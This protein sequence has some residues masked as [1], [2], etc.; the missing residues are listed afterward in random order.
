MGVYPVSRQAAVECLL[1]AFAGNPFHKN[2]CRITVVGST[3]GLAKRSG[4][5]PLDVQKMNWAGG[6][7]RLVLS[8]P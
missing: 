5:E 4:S 3:I 6:H 8:Y 7:F 1:A 2:G